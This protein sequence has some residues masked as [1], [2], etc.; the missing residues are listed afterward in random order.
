ME[1]A[2]GERLKREYG[3]SFDDQIAMAATP[4]R[5]ANR[6]RMESAGKSESLIQANVD[7]LRNIQ[8]NSGIEMYV[9]GLMGCKGDAYTGNDA[10]SENEAY[11]LHRWAA[12]C[13]A[14]A[15]VDYLYAAIMPV[16]SEAAVPWNSSK[17]FASFI[18]RTRW[19]CQSL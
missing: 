18:C 4:T 10:L 14:R 3:L 12:D 19:G 13:F 2:L 7:Y 11:E 15:K 8:I 6:E 16:L 9:G 17:Y 5:R 1:G